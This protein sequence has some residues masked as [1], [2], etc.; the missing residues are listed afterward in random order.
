MI[1]LLKS[2]KLLFVNLELLNNEINN[3]LT[4]GVVANKILMQSLNSLSVKHREPC[5]LR[6]KYLQ[7]GVKFKDTSKIKDR[8]EEPESAEK[9]IQ[10]K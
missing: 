2:I 5:L 10:K 8:L 3:I 1:Q 6:E 7:N 4:E 9:D